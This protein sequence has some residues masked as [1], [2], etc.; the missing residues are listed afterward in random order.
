MTRKIRI[1][2]A[3]LANDAVSLEKFVHQA[4]KFTDFVQV[5]IMD[6]EFV[7]SHSISFKDI[8][9]LKPKFKWEA[10]LMVQHPEDYLEGFKQAGAQKIIFHFE[11]KTN[12][13]TT[14]K[15]I[16]KLKMRVGMAVNPKTSIKEFAPLAMLADSILFLSVEPGFYGAK[17]IPEVLDKIVKFRQTYPKTATGID[18]GVKEENVREIAQTGV[19]NICVGSAIFNKPDPAAAYRRLVELTV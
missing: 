5:D 7:P 16:R 17:F 3:I 6:G 10:H 14:I 11:A 18:G 8:A 4:E 15:A 1:V 12:Y 19:D 13:V 9:P 2:P